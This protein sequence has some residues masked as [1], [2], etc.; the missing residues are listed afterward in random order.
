MDL[1]LQRSRSIIKT[2][3]SKDDRSTEVRF[4]EYHNGSQI[5]V[6]PIPDLDPADK[7]DPESYLELE[8][9]EEEEEDEIEEELRNQ[10]DSLSLSLFLLAQS[11]SSLSLSFFLRLA[12]DNERQFKEGETMLNLNRR[13]YYL[14]NFIFGLSKNK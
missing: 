10:D 1:C 14:Y 5:R 9:S 11:S 4:S 8:R 12:E 6:Q 7:V 13:V 3:Q 2:S